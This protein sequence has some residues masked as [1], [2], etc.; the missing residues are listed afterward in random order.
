MVNR[1][2][3]QKM[4]W[5]I[6]LQGSLCGLFGGSLGQNLY[7]ESLTLTSATFA[8]AMTNIIPAMAFVLA[9]VLRMERLAIGTVAGKSKVLGT[10]L[11]ISGALVLTFYKG[12]ELNLWSTNINL[13]HHGAHN[14]SSVDRSGLV[15]CFVGKRQGDEADRPNRW[16]KKL[17][18][19]RIERH[20]HRNLI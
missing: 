6:F 13:L 17:Y 3:R 10:L 16:S 8:A 11:S 14:S 5:M 1:K 12:V 19:A 20:C 18:G 4:T 9:I 2:S 7:A 15:W